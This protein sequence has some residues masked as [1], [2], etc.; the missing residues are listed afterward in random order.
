VHTTV[1]SRDGRPCGVQGYLIDISERVR[2]ENTLR[3]RVALEQLIMRAS[4]RLVAELAP[5]ELDARIDDALAEIG[6]FL[7]VDRSYVFLFSPDG[8]FMDNTHEWVA[9][10]VS[11][12][13]D[14]C[15]TFRCKPAFP[16]S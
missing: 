4:T 2:S 9:D 3:R 6:R 1:V 5:G 8:A 10:G 16:G 13:R 14:N 15:A 7:N 12:E 11:M